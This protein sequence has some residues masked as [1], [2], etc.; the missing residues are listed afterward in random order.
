VPWRLALAFDPRDASTRN[1]VEPKI[2]VVPVFRMKGT[3]HFS[4]L[5]NP[6][7]IFCAAN[8]LQVRSHCF[9]HVLGNWPLD[10]IRNV[11][12]A[13]RRRRLFAQ[14]TAIDTVF[15]LKWTVFECPGLRAASQNS[16]TSQEHNHCDD[17]LHEIHP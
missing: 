7:A 17:F 8:I 5:T 15:A 2:A 1:E 3:A 11:L 6:L 4:P 9:E 10:L 12:A 13:L 16:P 14:R